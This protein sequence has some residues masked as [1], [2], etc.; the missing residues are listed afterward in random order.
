[1]ERLK[2]SLISELDAHANSTTDAP[3]QK[4]PGCGSI[5]STIVRMPSYCPHYAALKCGECDQ[6]LTWQQKPE[7]EGKRRDLA[8]R[9]NKLTSR[10]GLTHW[11]KEFLLGLKQQKKISPKQG[12]VLAKIEARLGGVQ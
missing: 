6:F 3:E 10:P 4:C 1:M 5:R 2:S 11:E 8:V 12:E 7:T 9:L